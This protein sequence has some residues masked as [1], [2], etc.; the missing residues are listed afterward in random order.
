MKDIVAQRVGVF[1]DTQNIYY[2]ARHLYQALVNFEALLK[3]AVRGRVLVRAV[4]YV[5]RS[6]DMKKEEFF[7]ALGNMGYE[8]K[9][10]DLQVFADGSKKGDWDVGIAVDMIE[11][12]PKLDTMVLVSG[13]GDFVPA[14]EH[15]QRGLGCRVEVM[16]FGPSANAQ[17]K[18][19]CDQ[20]IDLDKESSKYLMKKNGKSKRK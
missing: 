14:V 18:E 5:V 6:D 3:Q 9:S 7:K 10:K 17:V 13:D 11:Q 19:V 1:V 12:A 8:I 15:L 20:F 2:S 16:A 4:A